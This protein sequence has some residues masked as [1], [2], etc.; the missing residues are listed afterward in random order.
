MSN[1]GEKER[2]FERLETAI[3][4]A[5]REDGAADAE[6]DVAIDRVSGTI[7]A[8]VDG[9]SVNMAALGRIAARAG[10]RVLADRRPQA[11]DT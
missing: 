6:I 2:I 8:T 9:R 10:K 11:N 4:D 1:D 5:L 7:S 3:I